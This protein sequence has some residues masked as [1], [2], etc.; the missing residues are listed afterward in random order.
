MVDEYWESKC[1]PF[2]GEC[3]GISCH[4]D[5]RSGDKE[6]SP[7]AVAKDFAEHQLQGL[8]LLVSPAFSL[9]PFQKDATC[10]AAHCCPLA[11]LFCVCMESSHIILQGRSEAQSQSI[12]S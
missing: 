3:I 9:I 1:L 7:D 10:Q 2:G 11:L 12:C 8:Q 5:S 6:A 4:W